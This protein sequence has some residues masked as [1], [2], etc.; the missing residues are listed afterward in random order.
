MAKKVYKL[1]T[2]YPQEVKKYRTSDGKEFE[3]LKAAEEHEEDLKNPYYVMY[4]DNCAELQKA[5]QKL[6][7]KE[8]E[9]EL[10]NKRIEELQKDLLKGPDRF[11]TQLPQTDPWK[12]PCPSFPIVNPADPS[13]QPYRWDAIEISKMSD[14]EL[15]DKGYHVYYAGHNR[16]VIPPSDPLKAH[17]DNIKTNK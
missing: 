7:E 2:D 16:A 12:K 14:E 10:L 1:K 3:A 11:P 4:K 8:A 5:V 6:N 17:F 13:Q 15:I 9:I